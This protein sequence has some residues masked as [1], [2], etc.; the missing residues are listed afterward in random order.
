M[1]S[2]P[3]RLFLTQQIGYW[4]INMATLLC[5]L[6]LYLFYERNFWLHG[7]STHAVS[8]RAHAR[9]N[10]LRKYCDIT[11]IC[12]T[13][14]FGRV[15]TGDLRAALASSGI[16]VTCFQCGDGDLGDREL[17]TGSE[18]VFGP[19][20]LGSGDFGVNGLI[21]TCFRACMMWTDRGVTSPT[22]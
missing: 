5:V 16:M 6:Y 13:A 20:L 10:T 7:S 2:D 17:E 3:A 1:T 9:H 22:H 14:V 18:T 8:R 4:S 11:V 15:R 19:N 21:G 12:A